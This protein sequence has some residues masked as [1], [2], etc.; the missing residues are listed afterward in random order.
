MI[1]HLISTA[2]NFDDNLPYLR[3]IQDAIDKQGASLAI[4]W[5]ESINLRLQ[6]SAVIK[7]QLDWDRII[8][9]HTRALMKADAVIIEASFY[10]F[11]SGFNTAVALMNQKPTLLLR[12]TTEDEDL[13][14][15]ELY[16]SGI[17]NE[18]F[19]AKLYK[20]QTELKTIVKQF[21]TEQDRPKTHISLSLPKNLDQQLTKVAKDTGRQKSEV[22]QLILEN[23][24][25]KFKN[26]DLAG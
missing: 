14:L 25:N 20:T 21:L 11:S 13:S 15:N 19:Q 22:I 16:I 10:R 3:I 4:N 26:L 18:L 7:D 24:F 23:E 17:T 8:R 12:R 5:I 2:H 1:I 9:T 6:K